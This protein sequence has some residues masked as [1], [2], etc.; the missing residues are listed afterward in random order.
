MSEY[1]YDLATLG[2]C[3]HQ[4]N[5]IIEDPWMTIFNTAINFVF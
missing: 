3:V 5:F 4:A 2:R 1:L